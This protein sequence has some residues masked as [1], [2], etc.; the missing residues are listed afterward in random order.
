LRGGGG[1]N[2]AFEIPGGLGKALL[3]ITF[4][5]NDFTGKPIWKETDTNTEA[6]AKIA[7]HLLKAWLPSLTPPI[8]GTG[9]T[10]GHTIGALR[11]VTVPE[12]RLPGE[13]PISPTD[14]AGREGTSISR[15]EV[16]GA[17]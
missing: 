13:E 8:P 6:G 2:I 4:N 12:L 7:N 5:K 10:G 15:E 9:F 1:S 3:E 14:Y 11:G 17:G 16:E